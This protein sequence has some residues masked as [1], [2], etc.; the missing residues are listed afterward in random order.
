ML[1]MQAKG[2]VTGVAR[3]LSGEDPCT[4][5]IRQAG[6]GSG[7]TGWPRSR[8]G[9]GTRAAGAGTRAAGAGAGAGGKRPRLSAGGLQ[10]AR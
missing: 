7:A 2:G 5:W 4:A 9:A 6:G 8:T 10:A 3:W 1:A